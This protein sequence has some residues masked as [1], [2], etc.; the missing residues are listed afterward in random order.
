MIRSNPVRRSAWLFAAW[1]GACMLLTGCGGGAKAPSS[2][3][4]HGGTTESGAKVASKDASV[5]PKKNAAKNEVYKDGAGNKFIGP[6]PYDAFYENPLAVA[7]NSAKVAS[8]APAADAKPAPMGDTVAKTETAEPAASGGTPAAAPAG[9]DSDWGTILSGKDVEDEVKE[10]RNRAAAGLTAVGQYNGR[11]KEIQSDGAVVAALAA[12]TQQHPDKVTWKDRAKFVREY[13]AE[14]EKSAAGGLGKKPFE[15]T[16]A[17]FEKLTSVLDGNAPA[18]A[19]VPDDAP[20]HEKASRKMLMR[21]MEK[22]KDWMRKEMTTEAK[23]KAEI[24]KVSHEAAILGALTKAQATDG[25]EMADDEG[26]RKHVKE[27]IEAAVMI[28]KSVETQDF[29]TFDTAISNVQKKC[30]GCHQDYVGGA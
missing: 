1:C 24:E 11:Y 22:A 7:N 23:Y 25:Y 14:V 6:I 4:E 2:T 9:G 16:Q 21:R 3:V 20:L 10:I 30:D 5:G 13:G 18:D 15:S 28:R 26:Y 27:M 17:S 29:K 12:I 8:A 19:N